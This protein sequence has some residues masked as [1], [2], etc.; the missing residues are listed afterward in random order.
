MLF[1]KE[2]G[3]FLLECFELCLLGQVPIT[4]LSLQVLGVLGVE[5]KVFVEGDAS[6]LQ[7]AFFA[8]AITFSLDLLTLT[9]QA[10]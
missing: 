1:D 9:K 2:V 3:P 10:I 6:I 7:E 8:S 4:S 5:A